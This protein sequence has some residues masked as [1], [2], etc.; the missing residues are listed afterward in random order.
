MHL[1]H[2]NLCAF[3]QQPAL[4]FNLTIQHQLRAKDNS[5]KPTQS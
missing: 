3:L 2:T 4:S 5:Y 1:K